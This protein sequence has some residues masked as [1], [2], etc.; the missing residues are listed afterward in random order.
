MDEK[1]DLLFRKKKQNISDTFYFF[2]YVIY[3]TVSGVDLLEP[4]SSVW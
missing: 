3:F 1:V 2:L 4:P